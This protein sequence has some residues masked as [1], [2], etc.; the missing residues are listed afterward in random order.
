MSSYL[1]KQRIRYSFGKI[2]NNV[3]IPNLIKVQ[4]KSYED[5]LQLNTDVR[6]REVKGLEEVLQSVFCVNDSEGKARLEYENY[7]LGEA[8]YTPEECIKRGVNYA[9]PLRVK[10]RLILWDLESS[11]SREIKGIKE[12]EVYLGDIPLMTDNGTFIINGAQR[13]IVSQLHRSPG[14]FYTHDEGKHSTSGKYI[15]SARIIPYRGS[16]IDFEF[17]TK[18]IVYFRI[19]RKR[20]IHV[21]TL[22]RAIGYSTS[23]ILKTFHSIIKYTVRDGKFIA[24]FDPVKN[25]GTKIKYDVID[26]TTQDVILSPGTRLTTK[27]TE[28]LCSVYSDSNNRAL[29]YAV[30]EDDIIGKFLA[31]DIINPTDRKSVV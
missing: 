18:D 7:S 25:C 12:Q 17:D 22:L 15:Y 21:S 8:K 2:S 16:W 14:V 1:S 3:C 26:T 9:S 6:S 31:E 10:L 28:D 23:D 5:F 11:Q 29:Y 19:D 4:K 20:K 13:V 24:T 27:L 30:L